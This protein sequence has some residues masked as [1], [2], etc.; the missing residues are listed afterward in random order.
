MR[1]NS[2]K[3]VM[4]SAA[5]SV[6]AITLAEP[7]LA[8][9]AAANAPAVTPEVANILNT[10]LFLIGG[11]LV[12]W[13]AAGFAMLEAGMVRTKNV[14]MQCTKNIALYSISGLMFWVIGYNLMYPGDGNWIIADVIGA[15]S[16]KDIPDPKTDAGTICGAEMMPAAAVLI[17]ERRFNPFGRRSFPAT[18]SASAV[19]GAVRRLFVTESFIITVGFR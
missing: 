15:L 14:A 2:W 6:A 3:Y 5:M 9:D 17:Q 11:F 18:D 13:M 12:M 7:A 16:P 8:Q 4:G 1:M 19:R 10:L